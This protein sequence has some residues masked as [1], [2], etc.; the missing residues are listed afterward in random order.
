VSDTEVLIALAATLPRQIEMTHD[1][2]ELASGWND[3]LAAWT[4]MGGI[5]DNMG[6][7]PDPAFESRIKFDRLMLR[8]GDRT[9]A[10]KSVD[11]AMRLVAAEPTGRITVRGG[12]G[13]GK[14]TLLASLKTEIKKH[15]YYWPTTDRLAFQFAVGEEEEEKKK[16]L[17]PGLVKRPGFSSGERQ[18]RSLQEIVAHTEAPIYLLDEWD[19][20][21]DPS[22]RAEADALVAQLAQRARVVEVSHRDRV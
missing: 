9:H 5:A 19:A 10:C 15:A 3:M 11:D 2:H 12:N 4:R 14:S 21:L 6:P 17:K 7:K 13:S 1:V 8:E 16:E 20:N 22:N 18:I